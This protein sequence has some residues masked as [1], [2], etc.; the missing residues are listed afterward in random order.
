MPFFLAVCCSRA[1]CVLSISG[2]AW[3]RLQQEASGLTLPFL[4]SKRSL[5]LHR[6]WREGRG[7]DSGP[8]PQREGVCGGERARAY[9]ILR[10]L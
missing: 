4:L 1:E 10:L 5:G 7:S 3:G 2:N 9:L 8:W 6:P